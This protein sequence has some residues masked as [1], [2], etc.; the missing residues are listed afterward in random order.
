M[1][2]YG[3]ILGGMEGKAMQF[4]LGMNELLNEALFSEHPVL[5]LYLEGYT[6]LDVH[7]M[8]RFGRWKQILELPFPREEARMIYR[9]A[10]IS[11]AKALAHAV[12]GFSSKA[13]NELEHFESYLTVPEAGHV[14][15]NN[16][17]VKL[18]T[19]DSVMARGEIAYRE[20]NYDE[21]FS[22]LREAVALQDGLN[23][24]QPP[25]KMQPVRHALGGLLLEQGHVEEA[26]SVFR[27]D[28][29]RIPKNSF[30][31]IGLIRCLKAGGGHIEL[32][33][34]ASCCSSKQ[35]CQLSSEIQTLEKELREQRQLP[36]SDF[37][38]SVPCECCIR[39]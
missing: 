27:C 17:M 33:P 25:G 35:G 13:R 11:F 31:V 14:L 24:S 30:G 36:W 12:L 23:F 4:A 16:P 38:V 3:A 34:S 15:H 29:K 9:T 19:V 20:G 26:T 8:V 7:V 22:L 2:V 1:G 32:I 28:L 6:A 5:K 10:S 37:D 21:A 39:A 18:L